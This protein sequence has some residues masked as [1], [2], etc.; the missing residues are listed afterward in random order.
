MCTQK[1]TFK[2]LHD[3]TE[4]YYFLENNTPA[5]DCVVVLHGHGS[6]GDQIYTRK[7]LQIR[8]QTIRQLK[9][10]IISPNLRDNAWMAP[11]AVSD[12]KQILLE[13]RQKY[14]FNR[15]IFVCGS[16]GGTGALIFAIQHPELVDALIVLG[17]ASSIKRYR[18]FCRKGDKWIHSDIAEAIGKNY[19]DGDYEIS[20]V[21]L[22][23]ER[24]TMP[25][26]YFHGEAD[27]IM[28]VSELYALRDC[29]QWHANAYFQ[30]IPD[31]DHDSPL[32]YF[33]EA[34]IQTMEQLL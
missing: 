24:L 22:H 25:L 11:A 7:D 26:K 6:H 4:D 18:E 21:C 33:S 10:N 23:A 17:A 20:D 2:S 32:T 19:S 5:G 28:P 14:S 27:E 16:M 3:S 8:L 30:S 1:I 29:R 34:L 9:L 31:G 15:Y 12:L 13:C